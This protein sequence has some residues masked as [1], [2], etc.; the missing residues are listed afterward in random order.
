M[1]P[2]DARRYLEQWVAAG[3]KKPSVP[4]RWPLTK[5]KERDVAVEIILDRDSL[6]VMSLAAQFTPA[7][8]G[9]YLYST[10]LPPNGIDGAGRPTRLELIASPTMTFTGPGVA[11]RAVIELPYPSLGVTFPVYP[12][13]AVT[14]RRTLTFAREGQTEAE[15]SVTYMACSS[16]VCMPPVEGKRFKVT[17]PAAATR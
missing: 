15:L 7:R 5:F 4:Q 1:T 8:E 12:A 2:P 16:S 17:L 3:A 9:F 13:G 10:D 14:L 11:D 6:G